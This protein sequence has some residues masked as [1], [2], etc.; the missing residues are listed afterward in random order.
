MSKKNILN[1]SYFW[2]DIVR[3]HFHFVD[4]QG[5]WEVLNNHFKINIP[6]ENV[7]GKCVLIQNDGQI[8]ILIGCFNGDMAVLAHECTHAAL[9][10][11]ESIGQN[12][13]YEDEFLPY[14]IQAI[15]EKCI[16]R[17]TNG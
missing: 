6:S 15:F 1:S 11:M 13:A 7:H 9:F 5:K 8:K 14:L 4:N 2:L 17:T 10:T 16:E 3:M 12:L